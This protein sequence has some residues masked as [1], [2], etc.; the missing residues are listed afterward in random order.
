MPILAGV[1]GPGRLAVDAL[2]GEYHDF[3]DVG[4]PVERDRREVVEFTEV[5]RRPNVAP[6]VGARR[7]VRSRVRPKCF[8]GEN[9]ELTLIT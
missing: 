3:V 1:V 8:A 6:A 9:R 4:M 2:V 5:W 7:R